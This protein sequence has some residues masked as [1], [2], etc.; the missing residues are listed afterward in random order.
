MTQKKVITI[1]VSALIVIT[2]ITMYFVLSPILKDEVHIGEKIHLLKEE[3][4]PIKFKVV[5]LS[6]GKNVITGK[7]FD[8]DNN[9]VGRFELPYRDG[10]VTLTFTD[11]N[12]KGRHVIFPDEMQQYIGNDT[13]KTLLAAYY[14]HQGTPAVYSSQVVD[15]ILYS[16]LSKLYTILL[17]GDTAYINKTYGTITKRTTTVTIP[18]E[19]VSY[20]IKTTS[21]GI[22]ECNT[23]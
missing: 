3:S 19:R 5:T 16:E 17:N 7:L 23:K 6:D 14:D 9:P 18:Q 21:S 22:I 1:I 2:M 15:P 11:I 10:S 8:L 20:I 4:V 13:I 12:I